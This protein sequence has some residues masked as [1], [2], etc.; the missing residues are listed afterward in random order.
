MRDLTLI[1]LHSWA[2]STA[3]LQMSN[4]VSMPPSVKSVLFKRNFERHLSY[5]KPVLPR[6]DQKQN[7]EGRICLKSKK[8]SFSSC[9][10][11]ALSSEFISL[12]LHRP[13]QTLPPPS[14]RIR[15]LPL[16]LLFG[17]LHCAQRA[18]CCLPCSTEHTGTFSHCML[19]DSNPNKL[20]MEA[21]AVSDTFC[22]NANESK[23]FQI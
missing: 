4:L 15:N 11:S 10:L 16:E 22:D 23:E 3:L 21:Y 6:K 14:K 13:V 2:V 12:S 1:L 20:R 17:R 18:V 9:L 5:I 8:H 7:T 19:S